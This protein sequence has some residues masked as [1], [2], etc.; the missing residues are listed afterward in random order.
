M[1]GDLSL[2]KMQRISPLL[3]GFNPY[4]SAA[5]RTV[6]FCFTS[7]N[8]PNS[9]PLFLKSA[10]QIWEASFHKKQKSTLSCPYGI[11]KMPL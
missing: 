9:F 4:L 8:N 3:L 6:T 2:W 11:N 7:S 10:S 1:L 5:C